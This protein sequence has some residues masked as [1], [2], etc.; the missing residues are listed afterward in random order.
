MSYN[1][2][3]TCSTPALKVRKRWPVLDNRGFTLVEL[4]AVCAVLTVL[5]FLAIPAYG[6]IKQ[7][8]MEVRAMEEIRGMEKAISAYSVDN[9]GALPVDLA[10]AR[11]GTP[12]DPWGKLYEYHP[13]GTY[14]ARFSS[15]FDIDQL[16]TDYDLYSMGNNG[17]SQPDIMDDDSDDDIVRSGDGGWVG[18]AHNLKLGAP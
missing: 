6:K 14:P 17:R 7:K 13:I 18:L 3:A 1:K 5:T 8:A 4:V 16:N 9:G 2:S 15:Q 11:L 12:K 10:A